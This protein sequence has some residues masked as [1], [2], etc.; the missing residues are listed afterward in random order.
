VA[1]RCPKLDGGLFNAQAQGKER[2]IQKEMAATGRQHKG[3]NRNRKHQYIE[4][5]DERNWRPQSS[6]RGQNRIHGYF[7][8]Y[9]KRKALVSSGGHGGVF[10]FFEK[11]KRA[12]CAFEPSVKALAGVGSCRLPDSMTKTAEKE[13]DSLEKGFA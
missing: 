12:S 6:Q 2:E 3:Q 11:V 1:V 5:N 8:G 9:C 10:S 13:A 7:H 4:P